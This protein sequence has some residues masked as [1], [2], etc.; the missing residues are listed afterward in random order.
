MENKFF[1]LKAFCVVLLML[2]FS[3]V[4]YWTCSYVGL[5]DSQKEI[6]QMHANHISS[7]DSLF[8]DIKENIL[9][10][11]AKTETA[12]SLLVDSIAGKV[13]VNSKHVNETLIT[14][15]QDLLKVNNTQLLASQFKKDSI[16]CKHETLIAQEQ[17][18]QVLSLHIDKIDNDYSI[19][20]IWGAVLS[21]VFITFGFFAI[22]KI[23]ESRTDANKILHDVKK[24]GTTI[25][26]DIKSRSQNLQNVLNNFNEQSS[27]ILQNNKLWFEEVEKLG[28]KSLTELEEIKREATD[29][30][31]KMEETQKELISQ[32]IKEIEKSR[33]EAN[34][35]LYGVKENE[36][37]IT[38]DIQSRSQNLQ[39]IL[40]DFNEQSSGIL[41]NNKLWFEEVEKR[42]NKSLTELEEIKREATDICSKMEEAQKELISPFINEIEQKKQ[43][44]SILIESIEKLIQE[45]Q[46]K[47]INIDSRKEDTL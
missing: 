6:V 2:F 42:G 39:K 14:A 41:Q 21:I 3:L 13:T 7:I 18:K 37:T 10:E 31:S 25:T 44:I 19:M 33:A 28:N 12:V 30:C 9:Q 27:G 34:E 45:Y 24:E 17:I 23:E 16:L 38:E 20:G 15:I 26:E 4:G 47:S 22:F 29:I 46:Q 40:N 35:I 43:E 36:K 32:F 8:C 1:L 11:N 5:R